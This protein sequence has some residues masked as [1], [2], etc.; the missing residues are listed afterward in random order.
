MKRLASSFRHRA[1]APRVP[2]TRPGLASRVSGAFRRSWLKV[3]ALTVLTG[4][5]GACSNDNNTTTTPTTTTPTTFTEVY[6]GTLTPGASGFYSF[7]VTNSGTTAVT[8]GSLTAQST[9]RAIDT[10]VRIGF[11]VPRR[12]ECEAVATATVSPGLS[13]QFSTPVAGGIYCVLI[14]DIG[15][16]RTA[17]TFGVRIVHP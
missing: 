2:S 12:E 3:V 8:L 11:G 14:A 4:L 16:V 15:N 9:G 5:G 10:A 1:R 7:T 6:S 13:A 17:A